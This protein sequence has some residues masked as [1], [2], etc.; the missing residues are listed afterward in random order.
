MKRDMDLIRE[1]LIKTE[2]KESSTSWEPIEIDG[3]DEDLLEYNVKLLKQNGL[4]EA[5]FSLPSGFMIRN[6][7]WEGH[8]FLD[9]A[10]NETIWKKTKNIVIEKG[11]SVSFQILIELLKKVSI[12]HFG[13]E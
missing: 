8:E 7:T 2:E 3:Y 6:L 13:L 11:G 4:I 1:I 12:K 10:R 9:A 5:Q